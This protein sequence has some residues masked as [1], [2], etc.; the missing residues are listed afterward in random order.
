M[1]AFTPSRNNYHTGEKDTRPW[2]TWEVVAAREG[3]VLKHITVLP[4]KRLSLQRHQYRSE[5]WVII[6]G[7]AEVIVDDA[8][9][10]VTAG[11]AISIPHGAWHRI[12]N[13]GTELLEFVETQTGSILDEADIE[14]KEDD[15]GRQ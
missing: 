13:S 1:P 7:E 11:Q 12:R 10:M 6:R 4:G 8:V 15:F 2:G 14:R 9:M 3:Y 5:V